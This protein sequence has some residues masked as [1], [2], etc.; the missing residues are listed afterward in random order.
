[1]EVQEF[2]ETEEL[3]VEVEFHINTAGKVNEGLLAIRLRAGTLGSGLGNFPCLVINSI[4]FLTLASRIMPKYL[5]ISK[6]IEIF[7]LILFA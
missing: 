2:R 3:E 6:K 5:V 4:D 7:I 1:M